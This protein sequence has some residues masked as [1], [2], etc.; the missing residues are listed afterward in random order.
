MAKHLTVRKRH[1]QSLVRNQRNR[2]VKSLV[3]TAVKQFDAAADAE[4][5]TTSLRKA[6]STV[7]RAAAKRVIHK[8][9]AA[10]MK[11]RMTKRLKKATTA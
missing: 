3:R 1:R 5:K 9:K 10:R 8:N 6:E 11:S 7:D 4:K 2:A